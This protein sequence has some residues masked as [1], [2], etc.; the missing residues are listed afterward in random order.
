MRDAKISS[1]NNRNNPI[2]IVLCF[3]GNYWKHF[4]VLFKSIRKNY[5][6]KLNIYIFTKD[7]ENQKIISTKI[8]KDKKTK[9]YIKIF[10]LNDVIQKT[11]WD[12][13]PH[14]IEC[15]YRVLLGKILPKSIKKIIYLDADTL[16]RSNIQE[17]FD[18]DIKTIIGGVSDPCCWE[19]AKKYIQND[20]GVKIKKY[21]NAGVL[22]INLEK[23]RKHVQ[24]SEILS[25]IYKNNKKMRLLDQDL[26]NIFFQEEMTLID[27]KWNQFYPNPEKN[28]CIHHMVWRWKGDS[29]LNGSLEVKKIYN[30]Y[31]R[32]NSNILITISHFLFSKP[33]DIFVN[34][35]HKI[36][37]KYKPLN[38]KDK[39]SLLLLIYPPVLIITMRW[40]LREFKK[41]W[42]KRTFNIIR[43]FL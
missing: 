39:I 4:Q 3:D 6:W 43:E 19:Y 7:K 34:A 28:A 29:L 20:I 26:I 5:K 12:E 11:I 33:L 35:K 27:A 14:V 22:L 40:F 42:I 30:S 15:Y 18:L 8:K 38:I 31:S 36:R 25:F 32:N 2:N 37:Y 24:E 23:W 10:P 16:V 21:I 9:I 17:L 41:K 1:I 13:Q